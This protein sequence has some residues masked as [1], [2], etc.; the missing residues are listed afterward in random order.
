MAITAFKYAYRNHLI[1]YIDKILEYMICSATIAT[2]EN[3]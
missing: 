2:G 3:A 1:P